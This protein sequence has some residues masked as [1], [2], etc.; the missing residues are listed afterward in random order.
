MTTI[1]GE[2]VFGAV[3]LDVDVTTDPCPFFST[4]GD[5]YFDAARCRTAIS[6]VG[7]LMFHRSS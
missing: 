3:L 7:T 1:R 5:S 6:F 2:V 4:V